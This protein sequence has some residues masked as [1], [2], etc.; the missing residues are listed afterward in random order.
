MGYLFWKMVNQELPYKHI[1]VNLFTKVNSKIVY[2]D[3]L[4]AYCYGEDRQC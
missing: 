4:L 1:I 2:Y 3:K